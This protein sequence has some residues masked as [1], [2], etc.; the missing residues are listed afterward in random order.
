VL[1]PRLA[2]FQQRSVPK[3]EDLQL[4]L[5]TGM[6]LLVVVVVMRVVALCR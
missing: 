2:P 4:R 6:R 3:R 5:K 1:E